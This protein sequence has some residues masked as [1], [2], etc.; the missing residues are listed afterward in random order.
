MLCDLPNEERLKIWDITS[1]EERRTRGDLIQTY[2]IV[3]GLE[4]FDWYS[5]FQFVSDLC[6]RSAT[7]NSKRLKLEVFHSKACNDFCHFVNVRHEFLLNIVTGY[8]N[9]LAHSHE[10]AK[11]T[12][13]LKAGLDSLPVLAAKANQAQ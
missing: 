1:L 13:S 6:T 8:W 7:S 10:N 2:K 5:G 11:N 12:N 3:N 9:E 4:S